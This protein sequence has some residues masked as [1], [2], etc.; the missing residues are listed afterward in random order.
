MKLL[1]VSSLDLAKY[2]EQSLGLEAWRI[3]VPSM[4]SDVWLTSHNTEVHSDIIKQYM[5]KFESVY[6]EESL[7]F[8]IISLLHNTISLLEI[9]EYYLCDFTA[10]DNI[11][12]TIQKAI[13][14]DQPTA[15][16]KY[17]EHTINTLFKEKISPAIKQH[18]I[19]D[20]IAQYKRNNPYADYNKLNT[21]VKQWNKSLHNYYVLLPTLAG[22]FWIVKAER[23]IEAFE[24]KIFH[25]IFLHYV[26][27]NVEFSIPFQTVYTDEFMQ[28]LQD[29]IEYFSNP[30]NHH[31]VHSYTNETKNMKPA[32]KPIVLSF[33]QAK[34]FYL[35]HFSIEYTTRLAK[36]LFN[37]GLITNPMTS[38]YNVPD[39]ILIELIRYLNEQ[40]GDEITLQNGRSLLF[41]ESTSAIAI[42]P[43]H[44]KDEF[45]PSNIASTLQFQQ[46]NFEHSKEKADLLKMYTFIFQLTEW[47]QL[48]DAIYDTSSLRIKVGNK[49]LDVRANTLAE[50]YDAASGTMIKQKCWRDINE[51]LLNALTASDSDDNE[52]K[53]HLFL[54]QFTYN[55][56]LRPM[57]VDFVSANPKRPPRYG[58]GRF[59]TQ[60]L[61]NKGIGSVDTF[62]VIQANL[63][64]AKLISLVSTMMHPQE[65]ATETVEW[66]EKYAPMFLDVEFVQQYWYRLSTIQFNNEDPNDLIN[67]FN[68]LIDEILKN[69]PNQAVV[70]KLSDKQIQLAKTIVAHYHI[71]IDNPDVFFAD[72]IKVKKLLDTYSLEQEKEQ[73]EKLF[74]CPICQKGY[75]YQNDF[76]QENSTDVY[77]ACEHSGCFSMFDNKIDEFF[78]TKKKNFSQEERLDALK[79]IASKQ[80][81]KK[82]GYLFNGLMSQN[83]KPYEAKVVITT[84]QTAKNKIAYGL[85][86]Q[87]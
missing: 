73:K 2:A 27:D 34:M 31:I 55:E 6:I 80:H 62:H 39:D 16:M 23:T 13:Y 70:S 78:V 37:A 4:Y 12:T 7:E 61:G 82:N 86:I 11:V 40:Y 83:N 15:K 18:A 32:Y 60:I 64:N 65:V 25:R 26:K 74:K 30:A 14:I 58:V 48:K 71:R 46:I 81:L 57:N 19:S 3:V 56:E 84:Y 72:A 79:N 77:Y 54:P 21:M 10:T 66:C 42:F 29:S 44:L 68:F 85:K 28:E 75:V 51:E 49:I 50:I 63:L 43:L 24:P 76:I 17:A 9:K 87:F 59:N 69:Q 20:R 35:N 38:S 36:K 8:E 47:L 1:L 22:L 45:S 5:R 33:L 53:T 67:E 41:D 52:Y